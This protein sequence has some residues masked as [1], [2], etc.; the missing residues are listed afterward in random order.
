[1]EDVMFPMRETLRRFLPR[2]F[3][4]MKNVRRTVDCTEF[5]IQTSRNFAQQGNT[6]SQYKHSNT[7][8]CLIAVTP[9][10]GACFVSDLL[11]GDINDVQ[12]LEESG[13]L[14][15]INPYDIILAD[16]GFT[17]QDL[18]NPLQANPMIPA[19]LKGRKNLSAAEELST[20]KIAK[21]RIQ[22][23]RFNQCLKSFRLLGQTIPL[24][25]AAIATQMVVV[26]CGL[27]NFQQILRK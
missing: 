1:M 4:A 16:R 6:Y 18:L 3:K 27:V 17:V 21:A 23:E 22:T 25:L 2:A 10:G 26:A 14:K 8:K 9:N 7:F 19:L 12:I 24:T 11:E 15:H 13:I 5:R 20:R